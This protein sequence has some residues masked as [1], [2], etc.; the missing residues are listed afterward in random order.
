[1]FALGVPYRII[2]L[3][4][5]KVIST[6]GL[7]SLAKVRSYSSSYYRLRT[8]N[9]S[10][11]LSRRSSFANEVSIGDDR[12]SLK[13]LVSLLP[14]GCG[15]LS[16]WLLTYKLTLVSFEASRVGVTVAFY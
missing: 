3:S 5:S 16:G 14:R 7:M 6:L 1:V 10:K 2:T 12:S 8:A 11:K 9:Q 15:V 13:P 4:A